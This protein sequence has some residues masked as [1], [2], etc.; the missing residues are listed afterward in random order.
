[1]LCKLPCLGCSSESL[2]VFDKLLAKE[3]DAPA[4]LL[5]APSMF[6]GIIPG[7]INMLFTRNPV[8]N[9]LLGFYIVLQFL[10]LQSNVFFP[11]QKA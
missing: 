1:M 11:T 8:F 10:Y 9:L 6:T 7:V 3:E 2:G 5:Q 4:S